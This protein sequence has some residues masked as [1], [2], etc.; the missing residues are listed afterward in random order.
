MLN[1]SLGLG[2]YPQTFYPLSSNLLFSKKRSRHF[3]RLLFPQGFSQKEKKQYS[4]PTTSFAIVDAI[5][6]RQNKQTT[7]LHTK[8]PVQKKKNSFFIPIPKIRSTERTLLR[9]LR[10]NNRSMIIFLKRSCSWFVNCLRCR[11]LPS[12]KLKN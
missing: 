4:L 5:L 2:C 3:I 1:F 9:R 6:Y 8:S 10:P 7:D 12:A 11:S